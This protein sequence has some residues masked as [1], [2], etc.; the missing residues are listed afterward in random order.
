MQEETDSE[1]ESLE[2]EKQEK[3]KSKSSGQTGTKPSSPSSAPDAKRSSTPLSTVSPNQKKPKKEKKTG[4]ATPQPGKRD[5]L[6]PS[7]GPSR[8]SSPKPS[9]SRQP[10]PKPPNPT[11]SRGGSPLT[12]TPTVTNPPTPAAIPSAEGPSAVPTPAIPPPKSLVVRFQISPAGR[13]RLLEEA[14]SASVKRIKFNLKS[15]GKSLSPSP[16]PDEKKISLTMSSGPSRTASPD[17][18]LI[19]EEE[20]VTLIAVERLTTKQLL[21]RL[22]GKLKRNEK[23]KEIVGGVLKRRCRIVEGFLVL[24]D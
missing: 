13:K 23:N 18:Y 8:L 10:S 3:E 14:Q 7:K 9:T 24:K 11:R 19:T 15:G 12:E 2:K 17:D 1:A 22:K 4:P 5:V 21:A 6:T 16:P 20:I